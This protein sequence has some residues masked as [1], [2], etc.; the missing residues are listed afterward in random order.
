MKKIIGVVVPIVVFLCV[1]TLAIAQGRQPL[2]SLDILV[3]YARFRGDDNNLYIEV[4][5]SFSQRGLTYTADAEVAKAGVDL[6]VIITLR[7]SVVYADRWIVPH[8]ANAVASLPEAL[9]LVSVSNMMLGEGHYRLQVLGRDVNNPAR[10]DSVTMPLNVKMLTTE[11]E[12]LSDV[13]FASN[14]TRGTKGSPFYK[15]TL[16]VIPNVSG[17]YSESQRCFYYVEAYNLLAG[18]DRS[19][20]LVKTSVYDAIGRE[21][22]SRERPKKRTGESS[23]L[24]DELDV[25]RLRSGTYTLLISLLDSSK[26]T[27]TATG[28]KFFVYNPALGIDSTMLSVASGS[29]VN[30]YSVMEEPEMDREFQ[31]LRY[32]ALDTE[33]DQFKALKGVDAKRKFLS[34]FWNRREPGLR[35]L[36]LERVTHA[37]ENFRVLGR[38]GYRSDRG[39]VFVM[40][41]PPDDIDRHPNEADTR[42]YEVWTYNNIQ[43]GV[44][45]VFVLRQDGGDYE[46]VHSTHRNELHDENWGR[47]ARTN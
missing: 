19:D 9:N 2:D 18:T 16:E 37:N 46:L 11:K 36:Y 15:N 29:R 40:Y 7:D 22:I 8:T 25:G 26:V 35:D 4:Y 10:M 12:V 13:E 44:Y 47:Y 1:G 39:R 33:K 28:K 17:I 45:F 20:Y 21:V 31:W 32:E 3:D 38:E 42:P 43:G 30:M 14:I 5:Y 27:M 24:V 6:T 41:G 34:D 23:V